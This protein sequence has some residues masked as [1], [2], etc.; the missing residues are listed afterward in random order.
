MHTVRYLLT[1][2]G[3]LLFATF[4]FGLMAAPGLLSDRDDTVPNR[5]AAVREAVR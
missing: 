3:A 5:A 2:A 1:A 4:L